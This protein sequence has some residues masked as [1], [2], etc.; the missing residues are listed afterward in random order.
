M[1]TYQLTLIN[2]TKNL[3]TTVDIKEGVTI[4]EAANEADI[5]LPFLCKTGDCYS[6]VC[7]LVSGTVNQGPQTVLADSHIAAGYVLACSSTATSDISIE[8]HKEKE[9]VL[10]RKEN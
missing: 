10:F 5:R 7:K 1:P 3:N 2:E 6:C 8:T 4:L 9:Y